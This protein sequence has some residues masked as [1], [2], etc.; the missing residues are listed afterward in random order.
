MTESWNVH[1]ICIPEEVWNPVATRR[2]K[3]FQWSHSTGD[4]E[5]AQLPSSQWKD[6]FA[7]G[8]SHRWEQPQRA[9]H[10]LLD[11]DDVLA[12]VSKHHIVESFSF[13]SCPVFFGAQ[14]SELPPSQFL[15]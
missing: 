4:K 10:F 11:M 12:A 7:E 9:H 14:A 1:Y 5:R 6:L 2:T 8:T 3:T 13:F 15:F